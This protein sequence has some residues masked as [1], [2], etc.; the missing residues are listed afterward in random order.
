MAGD[1]LVFIAMGMTV[2]GT[3][4]YLTAPGLLLPQPLLWGGLITQ[5]ILQ[6]G[7]LGA[8]KAISRAGVIVA[9]LGIAVFLGGS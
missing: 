6:F 8:S 2:A 5:V 9:I 1:I 3:L 7:L 4:R